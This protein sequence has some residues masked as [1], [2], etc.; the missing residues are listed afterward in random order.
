METNLANAD[1]LQVDLLCFPECFLQGYLTDYSSARKQAMQ[2]NTAAF[3]D[4]LARFSRFCS[5]FVFGFIEREADRLFNSAAVVHRGQL[6]G[7][8]RKT[9]LLPGEAAFERG[10]EYP[11]FQ[12]S[13]LRF[14]INI[15]YDTNFE[16]AA[17]AVA[18]R[19]AKLIV[20]PA[21]NM[22]RAQVAEQMKLIHNECRAQR[23]RETGCWLI[24]SDVTG[25]RDGRISYGPTAVICPDGSVLAQVPLL[26]TG[27]VLA[28]ICA[29]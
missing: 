24:S 27:I 9:H 21:N 16:E 8:Y 13:G 15:C 26:Q 10:T 23:A 17:A 2:V 18:D 11:I 20:C 25:S 14:G 19:G 3:E 5:M 22:M 12:V 28:D 1:R 6:I 4:L 7:C 29:S